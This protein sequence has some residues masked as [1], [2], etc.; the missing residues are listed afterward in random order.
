MKLYF[1]FLGFS[2]ISFKCKIDSVR[3][4]KG[5]TLCETKYIKEEICDLLKEVMDLWILLP[6]PSRPCTCSPL[7]LTC[8]TKRKE[9]DINY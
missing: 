9:P 6:V 3:K 1:S 8:I 7:R 4:E 2:F 5:F